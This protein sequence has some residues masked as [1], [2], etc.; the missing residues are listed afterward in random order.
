[1]QNAD[2]TVHQ[3][4]CVICRSSD[5]KLNSHNASQTESSFFAGYLDG[6]P[7][8]QLMCSF[9]IH[10]CSLASEESAALSH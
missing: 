7:H 10:V 1:M 3:F 2:L 8:P 4:G 5:S 9:F 6:V